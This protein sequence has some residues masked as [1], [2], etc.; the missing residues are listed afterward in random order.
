MFPPSL[1]A[2]SSGRQQKFLLF[3]A[4]G[5]IQWGGR[6]FARAKQSLKRCTDLSVNAAPKK[7]ALK[8]LTEGA[9]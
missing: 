6:L 3:G 7:K 1:K 8:R 2:C 9:S 5:R 4:D